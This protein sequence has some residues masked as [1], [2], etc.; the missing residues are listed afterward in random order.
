MH[1]RDCT[2]FHAR[3]R[4]H[5]HEAHT[6]EA[7]THT[8]T[9]THTNTHTH[10]LPLSS[11]YKMFEQINKGPDDLISNDELPWL[12]SKFQFSLQGPSMD[13]LWRHFDGHNAGQVS[14]A[15][16]MSQL[17]KSHHVRPPHAEDSANLRA[18]KTKLPNVAP[19]GYRPGFEFGAQARSG[20]LGAPTVVDNFGDAH[21]SD[22]YDR[23]P[24]YVNQFPFHSG[25]T[26]TVLPEKVPHDAFRLDLST[27]H[28]QHASEFNAAMTRHYVA[29]A[30]DPR[31]GRTFVCV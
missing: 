2:L 30:T 3:A 12:F 28:P 15:S 19:P 31:L 13:R 22:T 5:T 14:F 23:V 11:K 9:H 20:K 1:C 25:Q 6:H 8:H 17:D 21:L 4:T 27:K 10:T 26:K 18:H 16:I 24:R 7:H 29:N